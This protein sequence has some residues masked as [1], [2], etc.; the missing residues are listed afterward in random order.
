MG[1]FFWAFEPLG[2]TVCDRR[3]VTRTVAVRKSRHV[4]ENETAPKT[5]RLRGWKEFFDAGYTCCNLMP[6]SRETAPAT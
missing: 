3:N 5:E 2:S 4:R 1:G 6:I